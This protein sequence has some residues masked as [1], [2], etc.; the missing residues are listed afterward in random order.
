VLFRSF[1][2]QVINNLT[3]AHTLSL[4][5]VTST[6]QPI[7]IIRR[8]PAGEDP[9]TA[10]GK[11][12]HYNQAQVR[13][14]LSDSFSQLPGG[15][16]AGDALLVNTSTNYAAGLQ[17]FD[18]TYMYFAE[19]HNDTSMTAGV[20]NTKPQYSNWI[21][22]AASNP[23][24]QTLGNGYKWPLVG[25]VL[26]VERRLGTG[27]YENVTSEWLRYGFARKTQADTSPYALC[28]NA[29]L[30][31]QMYADTNANDLVANDGTSTGYA[32]AS[33]NEFISTSKEFNWF[34]INMWDAR[35]GWPR[36]NIDSSAPG[37]GATTTYTATNANLSLGGILNVVEL[38][39]D[40]LRKWLNGS[41]PSSTGTST[42]SS[43]QHGYLLYFS[44]RRGCQPNPNAGSVITG[45]YGFEDVINN[46]DSKGYPNQTLDRGEDVNGNNLLDN[47][48]VIHLGDG[49]KTAAQGSA[50][51]NQ[52]NNP[53]TSWVTLSVARANQVTGPRH[54]LRLING[55]RGQ[56]PRKADGTGGF[57]VSSENPVYIVGNYN[58]DATDFP[59]SGPDITPYAN[60]GILADAVTVLT[61]SFRDIATFQY[62]FEAN[63]ASRQTAVDTYLR[64]SIAAGKSNFFKRTDISGT[65]TADF[66]TDGGVHNFLHFL[67][68]WNSSIY[69]KG[70]LV[71]FYNS[72]YATGVFKSNTAVFYPPTR[73][74]SFDSN[75]QLESGL[76]PG[77]PRFVDIAN[78]GY[79]QNLAAGNN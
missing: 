11:S 32:G 63:L 54:V 17:L 44:D 12:R 73:R 56:L 61:T 47:W 33:A 27:S 7:E 28:P 75:L 38:N 79:F 65:T 6:M 34:P 20:Y 48:G 49:F 24:R 50:S 30:I 51:L 13:I 26:R 3:G 59:A 40:N 64:V 42:E 74:F 77:T 57:S 45:E 23:Y 60:A 69:F 62:P 67:E 41:L 46:G 37:S 2:G 5:F 25:G 55:G 52:Y 16:Q 9:S 4:P 1:N 35:E 66:G 71:S 8:P 78:L 36:N 70:S 72:Q 31:F 43:T 58:A 39:L 76:P 68:K 21:L 14:L 22:P 19:G 53:I 18:G 10:V 29:I 15:Q